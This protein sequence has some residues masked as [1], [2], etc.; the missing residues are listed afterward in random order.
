M[1]TPLAAAADPSCSRC[2]GR[3]WVYLEGGPGQFPFQVDCPSC[4]DQG[5]DDAPDD[6]DCRWADDLA[7]SAPDD[8]SRWAA[9]AHY[10]AA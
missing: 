7:E 3:R 2:Y 10:H 8:S 4:A 6:D 5:D 9:V 1:A